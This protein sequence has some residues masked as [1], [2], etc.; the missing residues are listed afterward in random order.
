MILAPNPIWNRVPNC[1]PRSRKDG[2][3]FVSF[4]GDIDL[5]GKTG[6]PAAGV[7]A[8]FRDLSPAVTFLRFGSRIAIQTPLRA[9]IFGGEPVFR[10]TSG[11]V[12]L[13]N[14]PA[15]R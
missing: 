13:K 3:A 1:A 12:R 15:P 6:R 7:P 10:V 9:R 5:S 2:N 11:P 14:A 8:C 4:S